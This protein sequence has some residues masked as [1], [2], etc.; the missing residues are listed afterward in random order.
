VH[1]LYN[2]LSAARGQSPAA[3]VTDTTAQV[4]QIVDLQGCNGAL[5]AVLLGA[6]AD[7]D[8]TFNLLVEHGDDSALADAATVAAAQLVGL[9]SGSV[10]SWFTFAADD[11]VKTFGYIGNKRYLRYTITPVANSGNVFLASC[12]LKGGRSKQ[13]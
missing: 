7:V 8:A 4:S 5:V 13:P 12:V 6:L 9:T 11:T 10:T 2:E 1:D 3:A